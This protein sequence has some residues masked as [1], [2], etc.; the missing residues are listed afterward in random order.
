MLA[1]IV[2]RADN[3]G[4]EIVSIAACAAYREKLLRR[5]GWSRLQR[6]GSDCHVEVCFAGKSRAAQFNSN[7]SSEIHFELSAISFALNNRQRYCT[8]V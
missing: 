6:H 4:I 8:A 5:L 3:R 1:R 2:L 7:F